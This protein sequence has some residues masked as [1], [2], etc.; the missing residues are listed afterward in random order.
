MSKWIN[1]EK[2]CSIVYDENKAKIGSN[3][4][5]MYAEIACKLAK[6]MEYRGYSE[7]A[8][9]IYLY[10]EKEINPLITETHH[11]HTILQLDAM[12]KEKKE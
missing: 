5:G 7:G 2:D 12:G 9:Q 3:V 4:I 6:D 8:K 11:I 10:I 1:S